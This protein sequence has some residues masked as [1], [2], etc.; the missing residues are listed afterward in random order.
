MSTHF[1]GTNPSTSHYGMQNYN[2]QSMPWVSNH[3]SHC[4]SDM[5]SH[6]PS[7][8]SPPYAN[9]SFGSG[10]MMPPSYHLIGLNFFLF[11]I[12]YGG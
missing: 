11:F 6:L 1:M 7:F 12:F 5:S 9:T 2:T 4:M 3:F 10:G 8:V